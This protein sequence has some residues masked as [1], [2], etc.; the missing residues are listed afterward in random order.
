MSLEPTKVCWLSLVLL[1]WQETSPNEFPFR[2]RRSLR[3]AHRGIAI[4]G[5]LKSSMLYLRVMVERLS[6]SICR[7]MSAQM[8]I[9]RACLG[10][11]SCAIVDS[12][13]SV[14]ICRLMHWQLLWD[15]VTF[16]RS[17]T[18]V[19]L[20][21]AVLWYD[22]SSWFTCCCFIC[23]IVMFWPSLFFCFFGWNYLPFFFTS[24]LSSANAVPKIVS[25][26][27]CVNR[28]L[29]AASFA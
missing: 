7:Y 10:T 28:C 25:F 12:D 4:V 9:L 3:I 13:I 23:L 8:V 2:L 24:L 14:S 11:S 21:M 15:R 27:H 6:S 1:C 17:D 26:H 18:P 29:A 20:T 5:M 19:V 22:L 16:G